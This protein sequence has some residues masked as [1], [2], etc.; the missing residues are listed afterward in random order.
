MR[1]VNTIATRRLGGKGRQSGEPS[2]SDRRATAKSPGNQSTKGL[3]E[4]R[5]LL[6]MTANVGS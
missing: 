1:R 6:A 4:T 2:D 3:G 5:M